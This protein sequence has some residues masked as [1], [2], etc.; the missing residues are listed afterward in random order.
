MLLLQQVVVSGCR[1][2]VRSAGSAQALERVPS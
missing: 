2:R 1:M